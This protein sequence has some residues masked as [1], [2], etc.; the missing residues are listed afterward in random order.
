MGRRVSYHKE[1]SEIPD[2]RGLAP[3]G[4]YFP[5]DLHQV[6]M[7]NIKDRVENQRELPSV[8]Q[9]CRGCWGGN[10]CYGKEQTTP[11]LY[12]NTSPFCKQIKSH[13]QLKGQ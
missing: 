10:C 6:L 11:P 12:P 1:S 2:K 3:T 7:R 4:R 13:T 5:I 9:A 8:M